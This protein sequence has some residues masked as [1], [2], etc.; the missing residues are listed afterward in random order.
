MANGDLILRTIRNDPFTKLFELWNLGHLDRIDSLLGLRDLAERLN[1]AFEIST[2]PAEIFKTHSAEIDIVDA[3]QRLKERSPAGSTFFT[4]QFCQRGVFEN[5]TFAKLHDVEGLADDVIVHTEM[6]HLGNRDIGAV[7]SLH[8]LEFTVNTMC[9]LADNVSGGLF[10]QHER[11]PFAIVTAQEVG[12]VALA[13]PELLH[14]KRSLKPVLDAIL[15]LQ[16]RAE[17][18]HV[19]HVRSP[20]FSD[21]LCCARHDILTQA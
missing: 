7:E 13:M 6:V 16:I 9:C 11:A 18:F 17:L 10:T 2:S 4:R 21:V 19:H 5:A 3:C 14:H 20:H 8:H 1:L 15:L 12:R